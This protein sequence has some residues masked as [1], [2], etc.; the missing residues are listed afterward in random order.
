MKRICLL[1]LV[2]S[3]VSCQTTQQWTLAKNMATD[4]LGVNL[5]NGQFVTTISPSITVNAT[6]N[7]NGQNTPLVHDLTFENIYVPNTATSTYGITCNSTVVC[8]P[9]AAAVCS[10]NGVTPTC[11]SAQSVLRFAPEAYNS[12]MTYPQLT[13]SLFDG[14][15]AWATANGQ[16]GVFGLSPASPFWPYLNL[17]F[18]PEPGQTY[19][20]TSTNY[21][22]VDANNQFDLTKIAI[23][24]SHFIVNGRYG[25]NEPVIKAF[26]NTAY[27]YWVYDGAN[28]S[29]WSDDDGRSNVSMCVDNTQNNFFFVSDYAGIVGHVVKQLCG[30][31][32]SDTVCTKNNSNVANV[33]NL[34]ITLDD[35]SNK[36]SL[37]L[38]AKEFISFDANGNAII[39]IGKLSNSLK[40]A[41]TT[42]PY[43][44][45]RLFLTRAEFIVRL[46]PNG[47]FSI[48]FN[49]ISYPNDMIFLI[50]LIVLGCLI[51]AIILSIIFINSCKRKPEEGAT[52]DYAKKEDDH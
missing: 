17:A 1:I 12:T 14:T 41:T 32:S 52:D 43:G 23:T 46:N 33:D 50:I 8:T 21:K 7:T 51:L 28:I 38:G 34:K 11:V 31:A 10:Y 30:G 36:F 6:M 4:L 49:E 45:G 18:K 13:F 47:S 37:N 25:I 39:G 9:G 42:A 29:F 44:V 26:N 5:P 40:C 20:E 27:P 48:G 22:L 19:I 24:D 15:T 16:N 2:L 3:A 35:G